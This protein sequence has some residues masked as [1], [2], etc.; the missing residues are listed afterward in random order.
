[1]KRASRRSTVV[2]P[3]ALLS[4]AALAVGC[5]SSH[6]TTTAPTTKAP[7]AAQASESPST[8]TSPSAAPTSSASSGAKSIV[9]IGHSG[10]TGADS[11]AGSSA[12]AS[13][14]NAA[15]ARENSWATGTNPAVD[16][17]YQRLVAKSPEYTG[18]QFNLAADG[19]DVTA[20]IGQA[21]YLAQVHPAPNIVLVEGVDDDIRCDTT[22]AQNYAPFQASFTTLLR[23]I[24]KSA[25]TAKIYVLSSWTDVADYAKA[26]SSLPSVVASNENDSPCALFDVVGAPVPAGI[27]YLQ[28]LTDHYDHALAVAC[29]GFPNCHYDNGAMQHLA[30]GPADLTSDGENLSVTGLRKYADLVW[31]TFF[32]GPAASS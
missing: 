11:D 26:I 10:A 30:I 32:S 23:S 9:V 27:A 21:D 8:S 29:A 31:A 4:A 1:M 12:A 13:R 14:L 28:D 19:A 2:L 16:S 20:M 22:D 25:P 18:H 17:V 5:S 15:D 3:V 24:T 6:A 7:S